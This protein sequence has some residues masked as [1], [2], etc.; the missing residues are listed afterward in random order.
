[1]QKEDE[2]GTKVRL[3][4]IMLALIE[5]PYGY[6]KKQL[7]TRYNK[8]A[9]TIT[10]DFI[11]FKNAGFVL[12]HDNRYRYAFQVDKPLKQLKD[13][14]HFSE[15]DQSLLYEA[16]D[17]VAAHTKRGTNLKKKLAGLYDFKR[18][19]HAYLRKPYLT[20]VDKL[21][22][23]KNEKLQV[24]LRD[25][26]SSNS[27]T[28]SD[29]FVEPF[30]INPPFDT[31]QAYDAEKKKLLHFRISRI[32]KVVITD[33]VWQYE[34]HH[35]I[36]LTDVFR[37]VD[38]DQKMV[39]LRFRVGAKNELEERFPLTKSFIEESDEEGVYDFQ[40]LVNHKFLG[41]TN[42]ILGYYHQLVEVVSPDILIEH[43]NNEVKNMKF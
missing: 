27:N 10:N 20:K 22:Q 32:N 38:N 42:F 5:R 40:C 41:L 1:M 35:V 17:Q 29:R 23:A 26:S 11:A 3:L 18:L 25:Y 8:D 12:D 34:G 28:V 4:R 21:E 14:L 9:S 33:N 2:Y 30:H 31:L 16:I 39:H 36:K 43:L 6:T 37:I 19:G 15:E 13:L 7:A 24:T